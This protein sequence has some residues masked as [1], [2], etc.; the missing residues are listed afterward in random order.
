MGRHG[1]W[2][3][4]IRRFRMGRTPQLLYYG[5]EY[6]EEMIN[7][8]LRS[9]ESAGIVPRWIQTD[10]EHLLQVRLQEEQKLENSFLGG[11]PGGGDC[12]GQS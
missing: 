12:N 3:S 7:A 11:C 4:G 5:T 6:T 9:E 1:L 2:E 8:A 10:M